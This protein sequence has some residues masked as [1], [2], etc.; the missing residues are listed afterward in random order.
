MGKFTIFTVI[1]SISVIVI[2]ADLGVRKYTAADVTGA[3]AQEEIS[4][5]IE[6]PQTEQPDA[7]ASAEQEPVMPDVLF[8]EPVPPQALFSSI[9]TADLISRAGFSDQAVER[10]FSGKVFELLD[11]TQIPIVGAVL[12]EQPNA[13]S[14][15][16]IALQDE[17]R[18]LSMYILLQNKTKPYIDM[19]LNETNAYGDRS[20][21]INHAKKPDEAFLIVNMGNKIYSFA[22]VK[23]YHQQV[24]ELINLLSN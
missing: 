24:K 1:L 15:T 3:A 2:A 4:A 5:V 6:E 19:S 23:Q 13:A 17:I 10:H 20:F 21:Y 8:I 11:I 7:P 14:M 9:L 18:A 22:Y 12:Y 16:E